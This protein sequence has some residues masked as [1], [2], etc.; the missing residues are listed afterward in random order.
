MLRQKPLVVSLILAGLIASTQVD[1]LGLDRLNVTTALGQPL[2]AE[3]ELTIAPGDG[4]LPDGVGLNLG[5][6]ANKYMQLRRHVSDAYVQHIK[7]LTPRDRRYLLWR[8]G[9]SAKDGYV[10]L[11]YLARLKR[12]PALS[13]IPGFKQN[14][15]VFK[16]LTVQHTMMDMLFH[17]LWAVVRDF[18]FN[19]GSWRALSD[20]VSAAAGKY[21][22]AIEGSLNVGRERLFVATTF[23]TISIL[24]RIVTNFCNP[25]VTTSAHVTTLIPGVIRLIVAYKQTAGT[26]KIDQ[27]TLTQLSSDWG[28]AAASGGPVTYK[29][30]FHD[31]ARFAA[32]LRLFGQRAIPPPPYL[33][34]G[35]GI[36]FPI[37]PSDVSVSLGGAQGRAV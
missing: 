1:A 15:A 21:K 26:L 14:W 36:P 35:G 29:Y 32:V 5:V 4:G 2:V 3:V 30:V 27:A 31:I 24:S 7:P 12:S 22:A 33:L 28:A 8:D 13:F 17:V 20:N 18:S 37:P 34:Q 16:H 10:E 19:P 25:L 9:W 11:S 6:L 23:G